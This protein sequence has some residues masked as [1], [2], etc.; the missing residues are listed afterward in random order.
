MP[1]IPVYNPN[2]RIEPSSPVAA[3][4]T[5]K[6]GLME[7]MASK[8]GEALFELGDALDKAAKR[9]KDT[10][11]KLDV[12][13]AEN[14]L[15]RQLQLAANEQKA[16]S[17]D[18]TDVTGS[19]T[20]RDRYNPLADEIKNKLKEKLSPEAQKMFEA[21]AGNT[22]NTFSASALAEEVKKREELTPLKVQ[23]LLG[24]YTKDAYTSPKDVDTIV[25]KAL[26]TLADSPLPGDL[27]QKGSYEVPKDIYKNALTGV[28]DTAA[29]SDSREASKLFREAKGLLSNKISKL[30]TPAELERLSNTVERAEQEYYNTETK[31]FEL[32]EKLNDKLEK[33]ALD[34]EYALDLNRLK[35]AGNNDKVRNDILAK[36]YSNPIYTKNPERLK[37]L[38]NTAVF[39]DIADDNYETGL[40]NK[41]LSGRL[42]PSSAR[43]QLMK[44]KGLKV[45]EDRANKVI[46]GLNDIEG[47]IQNYPNISSI[48]RAGRNA[49][50]SRYSTKGMSMSGDLIPVDQ[51][52]ANAILDYD[53]AIGM[54]GRGITPDQVYAIARNLNP[55]VGFKDIKGVSA[56]GA[57]DPQE[58]PKTSKEILNMLKSGKI[59]KDEAKK[60]LKSLINN[61]NIGTD[62]QRTTVVPEKKTNKITP[63]VD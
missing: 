54:A 5:E 6:A 25:V 20:I 40:Y 7:G 61:L 56:V 4:S 26:T 57:T 60:M 3:L 37:A 8:F 28:L 44:D 13:I 45:S 16:S 53:R 24:G 59:N 36:A 27:K 33:D 52:G 1:Q 21:K 31:K 22:L 11:D 29:M 43:K 14:E 51:L 41:V 50:A 2:Q 18:P 39:K 47:T 23:E 55:A 9:A 30:V 19:K 48:I 17:V 63:Q 15:A 62:M 10:N 38:E 58:I 34:V 12:E 35:K 46:K 42:S 49:V 32:A